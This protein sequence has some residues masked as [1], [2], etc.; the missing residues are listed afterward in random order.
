[1][2]MRL[3]THPVSNFFSVRS[4]V[5]GQRSWLPDQQFAGGV[6]WCVA[7]LIDLPFL[8][9]IFRRWL[10][11]DAREAAAADAHEAARAAATAHP[12]TTA[13]LRSTDGAG[14]AAATH[15]AGRPWFLDDPS[16]RDRFR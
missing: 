6:L 9:L 2:V 5:S 8:I 16:L 11:A 13:T 4:A 1:M 7:E 3:S 15:E 14:P 12:A 10:A